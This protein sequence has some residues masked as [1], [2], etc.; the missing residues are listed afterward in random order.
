[1]TALNDAGTPSAPKSPRSP[2]LSGAAGPFVSDGPMTGEAGLTQPVLQATDIKRHFRIGNRDLGVLF[3]VN[4]DLG[5]GEKL[6][7]IGASGAGKSTLLHSLGLLDRPS[8][9]KIIVEGIDAWE[10]SPLQRARLRNRRI[11]FVFQMYH[12]LPELSAV[13]NVI[14]PGMIEPAGLLGIGGRKRRKL[15]TEKASELLNS[16]GLGNRLKHRPSQ[17]SGGE[18]Q[19]VSIARALILDPPIMIADE[20]TGNL[21]SVTGQS[22][23]DIIFAEQERRLLSLLLVTH[24]AKVADRCDRVLHMVDGHMRMPSERPDDVQAEERT[25]TTDVDFKVDR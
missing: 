5:A 2:G 14:L 13:E 20:P 22:I 18:K 1:V 9:G 8:S 16:F 10:L 7:L 3:G 6:G 15:L 17:L 23:L 21:D 11:G 19:R 24:D 25:D 12:L 4:M